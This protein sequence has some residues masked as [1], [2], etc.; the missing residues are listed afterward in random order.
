MSSGDQ[1]KLKQ[2]GL[3]NYEKDYLERLEKLKINDVESRLQEFVNLVQFDI[4][5]I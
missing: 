4:S 5:L 3:E 2:E 1:G